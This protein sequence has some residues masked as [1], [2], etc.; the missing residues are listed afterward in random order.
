[1]NCAYTVASRAGPGR[2]LARWLPVLGLADELEAEYEN[3]LRERP[4]RR[5]GVE[6][7]ASGE[8]DVRTQAYEAVRAG[9]GVTVSRRWGSRRALPH[10]R[11]RR[12]SRTSE[13]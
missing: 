9:R 2:G 7:L 3:Q 1:M 5:R 12:A 4:G 13:S 8:E 10:R 6:G 11:L